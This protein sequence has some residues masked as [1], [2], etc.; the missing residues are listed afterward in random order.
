M[1]HPRVTEV[2]AAVPSLHSAGLRIV[3][4]SGERQSLVREWVPVVFPQVTEQLVQE[5]YLSL[6][7]I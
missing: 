7:H 2:I 3:V 5:L 4:P 1:V 6:I